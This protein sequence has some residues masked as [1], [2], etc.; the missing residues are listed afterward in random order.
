MIFSTIRESPSIYTNV[1]ATLPSLVTKYLLRIQFVRTK[2]KQCLTLKLAQLDSENPPTAITSESVL[3]S[4]VVSLGSVR[5]D[6]L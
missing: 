1:H 4:L 6:R 5:P 3:T 2:R